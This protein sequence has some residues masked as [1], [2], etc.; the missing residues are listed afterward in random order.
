MSR[1]LGG[2]IV[3]L[4]VLA[5]LLAPV[6]SHQPPT[7]SGDD[8]LAPASA[9]H[10]F[11]TDDL[12][13]DVL[14]RVL[15]GGR[16]SLLV[17]VGAAVFACLIGTSVGLIAGFARGWVATAMVQAIDLFIAL[18]GLVLA[19]VVTVIVG[20]TMLNLILVL[21][22]VQWPALARLVRGQV[23]ALRETPFVEAAHAIGGSTAW[24]LTRHIWPN[25]ARIVA[26]Q[27]AVAISSAIFTSSSLS[28]LGL[29]LPPPTPDWGSMV[30]SGFD[31]LAVNP[32]L[33]T[34]P[35]LAVSLTVFGFYIIG[36]SVD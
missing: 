30:Q 23:I 4:I 7:A 32:W 33:S 19:L 14:T 15:Y 17:G 22:I 21:G 27:F 35:G 2:G 11:G 5:S 9:A 28:F 18:P 1:L 13:R 10:W 8:M 34:G 26:A 24:I 36:R 12:G 20:P 3:M 31:Y 6:L 16:V 25:I 29:G